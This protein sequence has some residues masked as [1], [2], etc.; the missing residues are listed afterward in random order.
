MRGSDRD[1][2]EMARVIAESADAPGDAALL[3]V[4][5]RCHEIIWHA[6]GNLGPYSPIASA[7][8]VEVGFTA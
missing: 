5:R 6:A 1:W 3:D 7:T 2:D 4:D 8:R